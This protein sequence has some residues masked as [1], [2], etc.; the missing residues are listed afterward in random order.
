[1]NAEAEKHAPPV[2][3]VPVFDKLDE[4]V[5]SLAVARGHEAHGH[6]DHARQREHV[7]FK[8]GADVVDL[9]VEAHVQHG[10]EGVHDI[11]HEHVVAPRAAVA[12]DAASAIGVIV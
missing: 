12:V 2:V 3:Y 7:H 6:D 4:F 8:A 11:V 1:M 9:A 5:G 10:V